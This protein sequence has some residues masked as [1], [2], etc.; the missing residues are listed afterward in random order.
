M[1]IHR[2]LTVPVP[3]EA[4]GV[5]ETMAEGHLQGR[6][7]VVLEAPDHA[8]T[9]A[10]RR[11]SGSLVVMGP[12]TRA[13]YHAAEP[14]RSWLK[15]RLKPEAVHGLLGGAGAELVDR[16]VPLAAVTGDRVARRLVAEGPLSLVAGLSRTAG[17]D[18]A[19]LVRRATELLATGLQVAEVA[20]RLQ[21]GERQLRSVFAVTLGISP[22]QFARINRVRTVIHSAERRPLAQVA[23]DAGYYDQAHLTTEFKTLMGVPPAAFSR[24]RMPAATACQS[25]N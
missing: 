15:L 9:V 18:R 12:R 10:L 8:V 4:R 19:L 2:E 24:G 25:P 23:I 3:S 7:Q 16:A 21:I 6:G 22:K 1:I 13:V 20:R 14:G 11:D 5:I 17:T